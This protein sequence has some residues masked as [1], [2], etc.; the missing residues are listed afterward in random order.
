MAETAHTPEP[1]ESAASAPHVDDRREVLRVRRA[2]KISIFML[3]GAAV[4]IIVALILTFAF[5]GS[6]EESPYTNIEYS[7]G[8]VFGFLVLGCIAIGVALGGLV[9]LVFDR[10][11]RRR[12]RDVTV[13]H[14]SISED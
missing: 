8:Q 13:D 1:P 4:G 6:A 9:A 2:P 14:E 5:Q 12:T 7:Q 10:R 3:A 11:S